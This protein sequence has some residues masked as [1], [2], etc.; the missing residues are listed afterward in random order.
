MVLAAQI[1]RKFVKQ[2]IPEGNTSMKSDF[3]DGCE[4]SANKPWIIPYQ[5][6]CNPGA[7]L[8]VLNLKHHIEVMW[9]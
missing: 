5:L 1:F 3:S 7:R 6:N 2:E 9:S 4:I 8:L